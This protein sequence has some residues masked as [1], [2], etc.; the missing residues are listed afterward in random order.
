MNKQKGIVD[1]Y[2]QI[3]KD[4]LITRVMTR[5]VVTDFFQSIRNLFGLRLR[6]Y[7]K[8]IKQGHKDLIEEMRIRY[9]NNVKWYRLSVNPLVSGSVMIIIY[10]ELKHV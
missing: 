2:N 4:F 7:E 1:E 9:D 6:R 10:G 3:G 5:D 8:M